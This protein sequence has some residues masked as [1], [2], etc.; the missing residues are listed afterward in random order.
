MSFN[1]FVLE[2]NDYLNVNITYTS[3]KDD[4]LYIHITFLD[5]LND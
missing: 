3:K 5:K 4:Y 1:V 2:K